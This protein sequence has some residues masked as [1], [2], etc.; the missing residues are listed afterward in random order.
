[1]SSKITKITS[2]I[3]EWLLIHINNCPNKITY[4]ALGGANN[5]KQQLPPYLLKYVGIIN[6]RVIII[7]PHIENIPNF[8]TL[9]NESNI[10]VDER[11]YEDIS[12][13]T[14]LDNIQIFK[15]HI[16][17][18]YSI[19]F[20]CIK[21]ESNHFV[22]Y[23][24][25]NM[26]I[27]FYKNLSLTIMKQSNILLGCD[28]CG[29]DNIKLQNHIYKSIQ[30]EYNNDLANL[31]LSN[32]LFD[33]T[34]G[35]DLSCL[36]DLEDI[37]NYPLITPNYKIINVVSRDLETYYEYINDEYLN[38]MEYNDNNL[39]NMFKSHIIHSIRVQINNFNNSYYLVYRQLIT[40]INK[41]NLNNSYEY[42]LIER[43]IITFFKQLLKIVEFSSFNFEELK[44]KMRY[45][46]K[47]KCFDDII[48]IIFKQILLKLNV[49]NNSICI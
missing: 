41:N 1:M 21:A 20:I 33:V 48:N 43:T 24:T 12:S 38:L 34:Y 32:I 49:L 45:G 30:K 44:D 28:Y 14:K 13:I 36:P 6:I 3:K 35:K 26:D 29:Y 46:D 39:N 2:E 16:T 7:D 27:P 31:F 47:Y 8:I 23:N 4:L 9:P 11:C 10:N 25:K 15:V 17:D 40:D 19:E 18:I 42:Q 22:E 5:A 37:N